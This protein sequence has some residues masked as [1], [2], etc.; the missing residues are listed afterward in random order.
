MNPTSNQKIPLTWEEIEILV[1]ILCNKIIVKFPFIKSVTGI[2]RGGLIPAVLVSHKLSLPYVNEISENTLVIDDICD[3]GL[4][5]EESKGT[6]TASLLLRYNSKFIPDIYSERIKTDDWIVFPW[7]VET[8][9]FI[10]DYL[11]DK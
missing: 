8:D 3:T 9:P 10:Q 5:L 1:D 2:H 4:T 11:R 6:Y 7:E